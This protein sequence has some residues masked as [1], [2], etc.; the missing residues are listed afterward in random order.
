MTIT[1]LII[2]LPSIVY[3]ISFPFSG[4]LK[5][6]LCVVYRI[7]AGVIVLGGSATSLYLAVFTGEQGGVGA[8]LLQLLV[9]TVYVFFSVLIIV[10]H[11]LSLQTR[12]VK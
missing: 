12:T 6:S 1:L 5:R 8:Y 10:I 9:I 2:T 11:W 3:L 7:T 4:T